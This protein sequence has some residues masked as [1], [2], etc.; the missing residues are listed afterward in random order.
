MGRPEVP[1]LQIGGLPYRS[2]T[3]PFQPSDGGS[4]ADILRVQAVDIGSTEIFP[5]KLLLRLFTRER[6]LAELNDCMIQ[7]AEDYVD[8]ISSEREGEGDPPY[9]RIFAILVLI[10]KGHKIA[11]FVHARH[12]DE[13]LPFRRDNT[14]PNAKR[15]ALLFSKDSDSPIPLLTSWKPAEREQFESTQW[16]LLVPYLKLNHDQTVREYE[17]SE[18]EILPWSLSMV[19]EAQSSIPS[20]AEGAYGKVYCVK[21]DP[22]CHSFQDILRSV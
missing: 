14:I 5:I 2:N 15:D 16:R 19:G 20:M 11:E 17:L 8:L 1:D 3:F 13:A 10:E 9:I 22:D 7:N 21:I 6:V 18:R 4:L 12:G